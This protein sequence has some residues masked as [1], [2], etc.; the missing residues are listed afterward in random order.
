MQ[1]KKIALPQGVPPPTPP[2]NEPAVPAFV[3]PA[4]AL[5]GACFNCGQNGHFA[6]EYLNRDQ[7]RKPGGGQPN[8]DEAVK[9]TMEDYAEGVPGKCS[10]VQFCVNYGKVDRVASPCMENPVSDDIAFIRWA[11][12]EAAG[13]ATQTMP[14][15]CDRVLVLRPAEPPAMTP[16]LNVTCGEKQ[17]QTTGKPTTFDPLGRTLISVHLVLAAERKQRTNLTSREMWLE[18]AAKLA[19]KQIDVSRPDEWCGEGDSKPLSSYAPVPLNATLEGVDIRFDACV[20]MDI[21]PPG[22]CLGPQELKCYRINRYEPTCEARI[23]ERASLVVSFV[24]SEAAPIHSRGLLDTGAGVYI[25]KFSAFNR[26]AVH[27]GAVLR[28]YRIDM[29]AANGKT[30]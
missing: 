1:P 25:L 8:L 2:T 27:T 28:P 21:I 24:V 9:A 14:A 4:T 15:E 23:D 13:I 12:T 30:I 3:A 10:G 11:E 22:I 29:Y 6:R 20:I 19:Y 16:T 7:A 26:V 17:V 5:V 18:L